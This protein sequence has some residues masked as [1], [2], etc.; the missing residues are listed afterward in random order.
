MGDLL[1]AVGA[2]LPLLMDTGIPILSLQVY[3]MMVFKHHGS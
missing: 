2:W 1:V 3:G